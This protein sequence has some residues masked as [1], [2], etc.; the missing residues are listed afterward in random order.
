MHLPK[1]FWNYF[2]FFSAAVIS[3]IVASTAVNFVEKTSRDQIQKELLAGGVDWAD[4]ETV[5]LQ[6]FLIG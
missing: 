3:V 6:V 2:S 1:I 4:V 5:G